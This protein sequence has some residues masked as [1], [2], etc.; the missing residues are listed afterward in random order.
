MR[1]MS[2]MGERSGS[3]QVGQS[4]A[5]GKLA[6]APKPIASAVVQARS[7][8]GVARHAQQKLRPVGCYESV[9]STVAARLSSSAKLHMLSSSGLSRSPSA[10]S[11]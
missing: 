5:R 10:V 11:E 4:Y 2:K 9:R 6:G 1:Y 8:C 7:T 3:T